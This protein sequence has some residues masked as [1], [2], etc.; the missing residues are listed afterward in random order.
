MLLCN[1]DHQD[2]DLGFA[3][4]T[5]TNDEEHLQH[6]QKSGQTE[7]QN[8]FPNKAGDNHLPLQIYPQSGSSFSMWTLL[9]CLQTAS[10]FQAIFSGKIESTS[11]LHCKFDT[12]TVTTLDILQLWMSH[13]YIL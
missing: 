10:S 2:M 4:N 5:L 9:A 11:I 13:S 6:T 3:C 8:V 12:N 7:D 1:F